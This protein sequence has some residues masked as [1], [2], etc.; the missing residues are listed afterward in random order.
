MWTLG[1][2]CLDN[3]LTWKKG[4]LKPFL[5]FLCCGGLT[6]HSNMF[7]SFFSEVWSSVIPLSFS[8]WLL[9]RHTSLQF[10]SS[11]W[12][13]HYHFPG[14]I[15]FPSFFNHSQNFHSISFLSHCK[16]FSN[17]LLFLKSNSL[18]PLSLIK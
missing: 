2:V 10:S 11:G 5:N 4:A 8:P 16:Y 15:Y 13:L 9:I 18:L 6:V 14:L 12:N 7:L 17:V 3:D 1:K